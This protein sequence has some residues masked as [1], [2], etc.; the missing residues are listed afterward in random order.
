MHSY[1]SARHSCSMKMLSIQR[2][3]PSIYMR[4]SASFKVLVKANHKSDFGH[5]SADRKKQI[6]KLGGIAAAL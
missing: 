1:F 2:P 5:A 3:R 6:R 4:M